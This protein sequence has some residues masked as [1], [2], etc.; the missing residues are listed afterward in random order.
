MSAYRTVIQVL[1]KTRGE[2]RKLTSRD[3]HAEEAG[4]YEPQVI[5][6]ALH[7]RQLP[8]GPLARSKDD[9]GPY[10]Y[11]LRSGF[12]VDAWLDEKE[13]RGY[14]RDQRT[15]KP[16]APV[17]RVVRTVADLRA[18]QTSSAVVSSAQKAELVNRPAMQKVMA[19]NQAPAAG[20]KPRESEPTGEGGPA[21]SSR[22][23]GVNIDAVHERPT[24]RSHTF[25]LPVP[26][27]TSAFV[28]LPA[29]ITGEDWDML[30]TILDVYVG[31][32]REQRSMAS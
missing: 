3:I 6:M 30:K 7:D 25:Q 16:A 9:D 18:T 20:Q 23:A 22:V 15:E 11:A 24:A 13:G 26:G 2:P 14:S 31:R 1:Q 17:V 12:D 8:G 5:N 28:T 32:L 27:K 10:R 4:S 19:V 29:D 21:A